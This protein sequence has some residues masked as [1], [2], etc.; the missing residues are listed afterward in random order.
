MQ[1]TPTVLVVDDDPDVAMTLA[2]MLRL[3]GFKVSTALSSETGL[4]AMATA[5]PDAVFVDLCMP[6]VCDGLGFVRVLRGREGQRRTPVAVLTGDYFVEESVKLELKLLDA[7]IYF[8]PL[9]LNDLRL[10]AEQLTAS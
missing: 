4:D 2:R 8:K 6:L 5:H 10:I 9:W 7:S 3:I 1:H